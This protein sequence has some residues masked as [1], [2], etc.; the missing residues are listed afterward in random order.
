MIRCVAAAIASTVSTTEL[1]VSEALTVQLQA[2]RSLAVAC[3]DSSLN[4]LVTLVSSGTVNIFL[5][6]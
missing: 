1:I 6:H 3:L 4:L 5:L 2:L